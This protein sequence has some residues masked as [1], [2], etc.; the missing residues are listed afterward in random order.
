VPQ[1][2]GVSKEAAAMSVGFLEKQGYATVQPESPGARLKVLVLTTKGQEARQVYWH[3]TS[4]IEQGCQT[5]FGKSTV[6][7]LRE[8]LERLVGQSAS[9]ETSLFRGLEP[10]PTGWRA[11]GPPIKR[12]PHYP[13]VLHR[14]GFPDGS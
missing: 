14:G 1:L 8:L 10:Y 9:N 11:S 4:E 13:M 5:R 6:Q 7:R 12:L 2:A 3:L